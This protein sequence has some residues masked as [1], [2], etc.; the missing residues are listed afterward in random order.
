MLEGFIPPLLK[1]NYA[2]S[3]EMSTKIKG[4]SFEMLY[5]N[6]KSKNEEYRKEFSERGIR[7]VSRNRALWVTSGITDYQLKYKSLTE[8]QKEKG[9]RDISPV[10]NT[11]WLLKR[12]NR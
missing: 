11:C 5:C 1:K 8:D 10:P 4:L 3:I 12:K 7:I 6:A 2:F 9:L